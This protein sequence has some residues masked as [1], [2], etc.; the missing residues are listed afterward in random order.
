MKE[1]LAAMQAQ[2]DSLIAGQA[3]QEKPA[4]VIDDAGGFNDWADDDMKAF[5]KDA[6]GQGVRGQPSHETLVRMCNEIVVES[7]KEKEAA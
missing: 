3:K 7:A 1:Q 6:S 5:I 4:V 2:M